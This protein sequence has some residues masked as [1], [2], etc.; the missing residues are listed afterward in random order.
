MKFIYK[1][2]IILLFA[3]TF[4]SSPITA[5]TSGNSLLASVQNYPNP[6]N[7]QTQIQYSLKQDANVSIRIFNILGR[8][9]RTLT[10]NQQMP[11]GQ[12][13]VEWDG[14]D[15]SNTVVPSGMYLYQI[16]AGDAVITKKMSLLK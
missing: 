6:F 16:Q 10:N 3:L 8:E 11:P 4:Y 9:I 5:Q 14:R 1:H 15:N 7:I 13:Q 2:I 12:H